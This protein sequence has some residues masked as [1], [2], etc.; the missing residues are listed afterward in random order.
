MITD[1]Y[2]AEQI[3][4]AFTA[5][6]EHIREILASTHTGDILRRIGQDAR[7]HIDQIASLSDITT[8]TLCGLLPREKFID[9]TV[10]DLSISREQASALATRV[11]AE[12]FEKV[13][14][15]IQS[16]DE[17]TRKE[18]ALEDPLG[19]IPS[20]E[21]ILREI[22]YPTS[23]KSTSPYPITEP[24]RIPITQQDIAPIPMEVPFAPVPLVSDKYTPSLTPAPVGTS[25]L[26]KRMTEEVTTP[27]T[28]APTSKPPNDPY[29]EKVG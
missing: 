7:L 11:S 2:T 8:L 28:H 5:L 19:N 14:A 23:T 6:P 21:D 20:R 16:N 18:R 26:E 9:T 13:R 22:E 15:T 24:T 10:T 17:N 29:R 27:I 12:I 25:I 1:N 4:A 3:E